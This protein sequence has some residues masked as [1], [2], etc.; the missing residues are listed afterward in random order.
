MNIEGKFN[1]DPK[2]L[3]NRIETHEKFG[4]KDI[5]KWIFE[6]LEVSEGM[7][8]FEL[9]SGTGKQTIQAAELIGDKGQI[10]A[11]DI[12]KEALFS[13]S[14]KSYSKNLSQRIK[15]ICCDIDKLAISL[16]HN[17]FDRI[18]S[19]FSLYYSQNPRQIIQSIWDGLKNG[20]KFFFCGPAKNNNYELKFFYDE[21]R[22]NSNSLPSSAALFMEDVGPNF[23]IEIFGNIE[24]FYFNNQLKFNSAESLYSYW[25][26]YNMYDEMYKEKFLIEAA[27]H[28]K[29]NKIFETVKRVVGIR[30]TKTI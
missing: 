14:Q 6:N 17:T 4:S 24:T 28:F 26:S 30:A 16:R 20:G 29:T 10:I 18:L 3:K 25:S 9:G 5:N 21:V 13:L 15:L 22:G 23:I 27:K 8:V 7:S 2:A 11:F 19:S 12:S 1:K